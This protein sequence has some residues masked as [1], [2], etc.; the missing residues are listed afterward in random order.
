MTV[1]GQTHRL[2]SPFHVL[3]TANPVEYEGTYP[4]PEAQLDRFLLRVAFGYPTAAEEVRRAAPAPGP[5][6]RGGRHRAGQR[7]RRARRHAGGRGAGRRRRVRRALLR[8]PRGRHPSPRRRAHRCLAPRQPRPGADRARL[9]GDPGPRLRG[10]RGR[11]G[12]GAR[13][14]GPP[15]HGEAR[16]LDDP[17][18]GCPRR[19]VRAGQRRDTAHPGVA[20]P[21]GA[22][23]SLGGEHLAADTVARPRLPAR[24]RRPRRRRGGRAGRAGG[25]GRPLRGPGRD[26][27]GG[28]PAAPPD[29]LDAHRPPPAARGSGH[30]VAAR[31]RR[32]CRGRARRPGSPVPRRTSPRVR[33]TAPRGRSSTPACPSSSS[34]RAAG[35]AARSAPSGSA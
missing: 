6:A 16:P 13:R 9:G 8:R 14:A 17:G 1:E 5:P 22:P 18:L 12:G 25:A 33:R 35:A 31:G 19:R 34:A 32:P 28:P 27:A 26:G 4:L 11:Q 7:R 29:G 21:G 30:D 24:A 10:A 2:P 23:R 20:P 15:D 3:A